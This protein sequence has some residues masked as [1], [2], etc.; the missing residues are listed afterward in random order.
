MPDGGT[1]TIATSNLSSGP[2]QPDLPAG[3]WV[4]LRMSDSGRGMSSEVKDH[5]FEPFF[6]TKGGL[7]RAGLGL[8]T[9]Y[10]IVR[11]AGG[12]VRVESD[13]GTGTSFEILLPRSHPA[14]APVA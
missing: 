2:G 13:P 10:G 8:S 9:V 12:H 1:V 3:D 5:L 11:Q 7:P 6:T 14:T 4:R